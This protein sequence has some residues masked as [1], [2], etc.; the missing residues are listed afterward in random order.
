M[1]LRHLEIFIT[2]CQTNSMTKAAKQLFMTQPAVSQAIK[3]L[4]TH[5]EA[6]LFERMHNKL[7]RTTNGDLLYEY[8]THIF[9][10]F[11]KAQHSIK[12]NHEAGAIRIG[13]NLTV[14]A[15]I[16]PKMI[17]KFNAIHGNI[18][19]RV[20]VGNGDHID[21]MLSRNEIDF[22]LIEEVAADRFRMVKVFFEDRIAVVAKCGYE[23]KSVTPAHLANLP[24]LLRDAGAGVRVQFDQMMHQFGLRAEPYWESASTLALINAAKCGL[25]VAVLPY[26]VAKAHIED[27]TLDEITVEGVTLTRHLVITYHKNKYLTASMRAFIAL[28]ESEA[29]GFKDSQSGI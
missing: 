8:A 17:E 21:K 3:E 22:A 7:F 4:E 1:T 24:L 2:V 25:G 20:I 23:I 29:E 12:V 13:A 14:G 6:P 16:L 28:V 9:G 10:L 11:E 15:T 26:Q 19:V 5:Y 18:P 27:G